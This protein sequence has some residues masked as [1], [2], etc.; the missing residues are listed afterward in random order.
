LL[1]DAW[2]ASAPTPAGGQ[3]G[4]SVSTYGAPVTRL[5][6]LTTRL[7]QQSFAAPRAP[8]IG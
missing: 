4:A 2:H 5:A 8:P 7:T 3:E 1:N 6:Q